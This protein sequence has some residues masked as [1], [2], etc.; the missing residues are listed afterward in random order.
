MTTR[1]LGKEGFNWFFGVVQDRDDP[2]KVGRIRVRVHSV[3]DDAELIP[4]NALHWATPVLPVTSASDNEVGISPTGIAVGT[5]VFGFFADGEEK[6]LPIVLGTVAGIPEEGS[7]DVA[8]LAREVN[9][10]VKSRVGNE[11]ASAYAAKYPYNK[12][13][14]TE[15]G[16]AIEIDDTPGAERIHVYHKSGTY[17]EINNDGRIVTKSVDDSFE[18]VAKDKNVYV[19]GDVNLT[20]IGNITATVTGTTTVSGSDNI[21]VNSTTKISI[22]APLV[23]INGK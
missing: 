5:T 10:I 4:S 21:D 3:H 17:I 18:I 13:L 14:T 16:H 6:Q 1:S 20:V 15:S 2:L 9:S 12:T 23:S 19:S 8:K 11:P 22:T 7:H